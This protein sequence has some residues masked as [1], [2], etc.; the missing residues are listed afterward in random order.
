MTFVA[1]ALLLK[2]KKKKKSIDKAPS[3]HSSNYV[4]VSHCSFPIAKLTPCRDLYSLTVKE[5]TVLAKTV[6]C[7]K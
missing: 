4:L 7:L 3:G 6:F 5:T 2:K 1:L